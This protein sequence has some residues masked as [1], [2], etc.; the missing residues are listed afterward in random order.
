MPWLLFIVNN[1]IV[2]TKFSNQVSLNKKKKEKQ[3]GNLFFNPFGFLLTED[4]KY[5]AKEDIGEAQCP[6][7]YQY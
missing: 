3:N 5:F 4:Y 6:P 2:R 7:P 1:I